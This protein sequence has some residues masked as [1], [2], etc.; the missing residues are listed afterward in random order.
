MKKLRKALGVCLSSFI[1]N[2]G[3]DGPVSVEHVKKIIGLGLGKA[4]NVKGINGLTPLAAAVYGYYPEITRTLLEA[5]ADPN[6]LSGRGATPLMLVCISPS[7]LEWEKQSQIR[8]P[9][10]EMLIKAGAIVSDTL[11]HPDHG[12]AFE[13]AEKMGYSQITKRLEAEILN[14][15]AKNNIIFDL[16]RTYLRPR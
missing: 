10:V 14:E 12:S 2:L 5:G 6:K 1:S 15:T 16:A 7:S 9:I 3:D 8:M 4:I 13:I 11:S